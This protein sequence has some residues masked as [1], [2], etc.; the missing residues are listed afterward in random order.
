M[1][2]RDFH[3]DEVLG[4]AYDARLMRRLLTYVRPHR[5]LVAGS[6]LLLLM[7]AALELAGPLIVKHA[8]DEH[9][10][11]GSTS[12]LMKIALL[13]FLTL[14]GAFF[15]GYAQIYLMN[16]MGQR[17]MVTLRNQIFA[18]LQKLHVQY[19]DKNPVGRLITRMT[20]DVDALNEMFTSGVVAI[21]GDVITLIGIMVV[22][23]VLN[24]KLALVTFAVLP[25]LFALSIW[26]RKNAR[27]QYRAVRIRLAKIN[28]YLQESIT[29]M[30]IIQIMN[31]QERSRGEFHELNRDYTESYLKTIFYYAIFY[32]GVEVLSALAL[33]G[34]IWVGGNEMLKDTLTVG[35]L[36]A[37]IQYVGRFYVPIQ[38]LSEKYNILQGAMASSERIFSLLDTEPAVSDPHTA[39]D[40][41]ARAKTGGS[42]E[43]QNVWFAY[44]N[45][46]WVL[47]D[48]SFSVDEGE[49]LAF[50]GA[51]GS[52]KTT[53]M[54]LLM[55]FYDVQKGAVLVDGVDVRF[56]PQHELRS[57]MSLVLQDVFLFRGSIAD[58]I[59][60][61]RRLSSEEV[62]QAAR[63]V[64][65]LP[66]IRQLPQ[67][68]DTPVGERGANL[69]TGQKQ[70]LSF[71]R[72]LAHRPEVLL[73][74]EATSNVDAES[75]ALI[76]GALLK[77]MEGRTSLIVAHRL[78]TVRHVDRIIVMHKGEIRESGTHKEL[79][80][81]R[82][83][84][85]RL[86]QLQYKDQE[87]L[88]DAGR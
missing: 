83:I 46:E 25:A 85:S 76:Q 2:D 55:R 64:N 54:N 75:E 63:K 19:Y 69:S 26:F 82:G 11:N 17:I 20:S 80:E 15:T 41:A 39:D 10:M 16:L 6:I 18:H 24:V 58:N 79:L 73:L 1:A 67:Q 9:V 8:V 77:L 51:T 42:I 66:F 43:F 78:S 48:V 31:R 56:W 68:F 65:A 34:V 40:F 49:K 35:A 61:D 52:G 57:R 59:R 47:K 71:A 5:R 29:G 23:V 88:S 27:D 70:L 62:T 3:E 36:V 74:D 37:F 30:S 81:A 21:F 50:V 38:D 4:K 84:Y 87:A 53:L 13:Y 32:P 22:L 60:L 7:T 72:A 44:N 28:S 86:Y 12:G 33:A 14:V 45:E